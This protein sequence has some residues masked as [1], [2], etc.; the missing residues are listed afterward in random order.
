MPRFH[1]LVVLGLVISMS[2]CSA[3]DDDASG[4]DDAADDDAGDDDSAPAEIEDPEATLVGEQYFLDF[5]S[6]EFVEPEG[7]GGILA[8]YIADSYWH[9]L[10]IVT[11][12]DDQTGTITINFAGNAAPAAPGT[13]DNPAFAVGPLD[14]V[15]SES[16]ETLLFGALID[17]VFADEGATMADVTVDATFDI[18]VIDDFIDPDAEEGLGCELLDH[19]GV[20]CIPC[21]DS[22]EP[23]CLAIIVEHVSGERIV[24]R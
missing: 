7:A 10:L 5:G 21:P 6:G 19:E 4:D 22:G 2:G 3:T 1:L 23:Y 24:T 20:P 17:G 18:R 16:G 14:G 9:M 13:W 12:L 11:A 15:D 8:Q